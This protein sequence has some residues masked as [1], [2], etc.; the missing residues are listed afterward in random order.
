MAIPTV[1]QIVKIAAF[2]LMPL[3]VIVRNGERL[4]VFDVEFNITEELAI[5]V[6]YTDQDGV[7]WSTCY[8][9][10]QVVSVEYQKGQNIVNIL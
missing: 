8:R 7:M 3:M 2:N 5:S 1:G 10:D 6:D 9:A 4:N